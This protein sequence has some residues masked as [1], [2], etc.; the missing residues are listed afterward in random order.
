MQLICGGQKRSGHFDQIVNLVEEVAMMR[1][2]SKM[3]L[4][5]LLVPQSTSV[6]TRWDR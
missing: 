6:D 2:G 5:L 1:E 3:P 4:M